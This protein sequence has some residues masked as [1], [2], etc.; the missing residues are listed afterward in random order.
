M[1]LPDKV[2]SQKPAYTFFLTPSCD[3]IGRPLRFMLGA[4]QRHDNIAAKALLEGFKAEVV[5]TDKAY[6]NN[7]LRTTIADTNAEAVIPQPA[8]VRSP[9]RATRRSTS[10]A[11]A[12]SADS[13]S[14]N[15]S[16]ASPRDMTD[17]QTTSSPSSTSPQSA[18]GS[19]ECGFVPVHH[20]RRAMDRLRLAPF[21][22]SDR[23][24]LVPHA[25]RVWMARPIHS[26]TYPV[27]LT[28]LG[29][30]RVEAAVLPDARMVTRA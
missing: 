26:A 28:V 4:G 13:T 17:G 12:S 20:R 21:G 3:S 14:S 10:Y 30:S 16:A 11:T 25:S 24:L 18:F 22:P 29:L 5:L 9:S 23:N 1:S 2:N 15:T 8:L 27:G 6:D 7:D 19:V